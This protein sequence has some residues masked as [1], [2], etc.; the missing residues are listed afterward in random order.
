MY[1][2]AVCLRLAQ[3]GGQDK[4]VVDAMRHFLAGVAATRPSPDDYDLIASEAVRQMS[5]PPPH[6]GEGLRLRNP[7][8]EVLHRAIHQAVR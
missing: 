6:E 7:R 8:K 3:I 2:R 5:I 1:P 4:H